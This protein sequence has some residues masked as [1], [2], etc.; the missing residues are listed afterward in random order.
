M[1]TNLYK[2]EI[3]SGVLAGTSLLLLYI[4][5]MGIASRSVEATIYQFQQLWY[6]TLILVIG[7]GIQVGLY[8][9][10]RN[11]VNQRHSSG[12]SSA[13]MA[14]STGTS[15]V[16]MIACCA[17][18]LT[19]VL[20]IIGLSGAAIF[21]TQFQLPLII[22]GIVMNGFGIFYMLRIIKKIS[23]TEQQ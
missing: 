14:T 1:N 17:H 16:S 7:F 2:H 6:W 10:M 18:H 20:P 21:L 8:T 3:K 13:V 4:F 15:T 12:T 19:E 23:W 5:V 11:M 9:R 22:L